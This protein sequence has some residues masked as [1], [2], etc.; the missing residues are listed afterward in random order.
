MAIERT[1]PACCVGADGEPELE[2]PLVVNR[3]E[4]VG[5]ELVPKLET[6]LQPRRSKSLAS[7]CSPVMAV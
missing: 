7:L 1:R 6:G 2:E 3:E 5:A 4:Q